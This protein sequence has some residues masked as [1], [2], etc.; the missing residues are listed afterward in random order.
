MLLLDRGADVNAPSAKNSTPLHAAA[1]AGQ[2]A[3]VKSLLA[4]GANVDVVD[5]D[6]DSPLALAVAFHQL[7]V[8]KLLEQNKKIYCTLF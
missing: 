2:F 1:I 6:G 3:V 7:E 5:E 4:R 8:V